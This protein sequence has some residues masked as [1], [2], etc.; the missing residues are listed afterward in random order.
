M[1]YEMIF[2]TTFSIFLILLLVWTGLYSAFNIQA[3]DKLS[4]KMKDKSSYW[5]QSK[6]KIV[7][8]VSKF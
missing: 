8:T 3:D 4:S 1:F 5:E 2:S 6:Y 7:H